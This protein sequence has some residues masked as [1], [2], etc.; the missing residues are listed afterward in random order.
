ME[1]ACVRLAQSGEPVKF[2]NRHGSVKVQI[3][4]HVPLPE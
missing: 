2:Y 4:P 1:E 3:V